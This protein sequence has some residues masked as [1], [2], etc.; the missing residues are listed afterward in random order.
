MSRHT[1]DFTFVDYW[2]EYHRGH[3]RYPLCTYYGTCDKE[4]D[5]R[6]RQAVCA[7]C[8][9]IFLTC[10]S[11]LGPIKSQD[12]CS[13]EC[14]DK[15]LGIIVN[16][17]YRPARRRVRVHPVKNC[18][19]CSIAQSLGTVISCRCMYETDMIGI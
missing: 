4:D 12:F 8:E 3:E 7:Q 19:W 16:G 11:D 9:T 2:I 5:M 13:Q 17:H 18:D 1:A 15:H 10:E 6:N 14:E